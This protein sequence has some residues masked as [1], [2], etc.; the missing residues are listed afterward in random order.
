MGQACIAGSRIYVQEGIYDRFMEQFLAL[1]KFRQAATGDPF[2]VGTLHGPQVSQVQFD[3]RVSSL[4][5]SLQGEIGL[6][7]IFLILARDVVHRVWKG[8]GSHPTFRR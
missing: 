7:W 2:V 1:A 4:Y 8:R 6:T 3:V 5:V